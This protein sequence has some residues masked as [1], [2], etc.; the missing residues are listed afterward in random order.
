LVAA[1]EA[2]VSVVVASPIVDNP[3]GGNVCRNYVDTRRGRASILSI[4]CG[5]APK[6]VTATTAPNRAAQE[7]QQR[8]FSSPDEAGAALLAAAGSG[9]RNTIVALFRPD[10]ET[11]L[12]TG[13][14]A[15]DKTALRDFAAAYGEMHRWGK[16]KAG[17]Q[18]LY[19]G[20]DNDPFPI[21][22]GQ[23]SSGKWRFRY[24]GGQR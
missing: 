13:D 16:I 23:D 24:C 12:F 17:A 1:L 21:P 22:L 20:A 10:S 11:V 18:V 9:D 5:K 8:T 19:V 7:T 15:K 2:A 4:S 3:I 14:S 6:A